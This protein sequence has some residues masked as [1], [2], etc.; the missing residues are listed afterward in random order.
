MHRDAK[1]VYVANS[2]GEADV[3]AVWLEEQGFATRVMNMSTLG[4]IAGLTP[5][6]PLGISPGGIEVWVLD[7]PKAPLAKQ[8]LDEHS[9]S[10]VRQAAAAAEQNGPIE[11]CCEECGRTAEFPAQQRGSVQECPH[12]GEYLDIG[13]PGHGADEVSGAASEDHDEN[14]DG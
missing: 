14:G 5:Y 1:C 2:P 9:Q 6:S 7:E 3:V 11:V 10:L 8:M 4:G 13:D 12:C